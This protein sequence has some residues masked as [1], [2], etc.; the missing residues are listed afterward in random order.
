MG[1]SKEGYS[2]FSPPSLFFCHRFVPTCPG[3]SGIVPTCPRH[4][5]IVPGCP[6][7]SGII[8]GCPGHVTGFCQYSR[9]F[10][11]LSQLFYSSVTVFLTS[12]P[13][14]GDNFG[15]VRDITG[16]YISLH[17]ALLGHTL[18]TGVHS[19]AKLYLTLVFFRVLVGNL[20]TLFFRVLS[21][22][23]LTTKI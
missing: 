7:H 14:N 5:G 16:Y 11:R 23:L 3:H 21:E 12:V 15:R 22:N 2:G 17:C 9:V 19:L 8:P 20:L 10:I 1:F 18:F 13:K 6:R 4:S